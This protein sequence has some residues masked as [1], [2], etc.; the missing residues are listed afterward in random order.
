V[1][2]ELGVLRANVDLVLNFFV[3]HVIGGWAHRGDS[4]AKWRLALK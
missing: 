3:G 4:C 1:R 2:Y